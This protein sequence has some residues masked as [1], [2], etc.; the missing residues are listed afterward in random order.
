MKVAATVLGPTLAGGVIKRRP[1]MMG[2]LEKMQADTNAVRLM[3]DLRSRYRAPLVELAVPG[4]SFALVLSADEVGRVLAE[5]PEP[6]SPANLEKR[7]AL[8]KFQPHG[9]LIS[10]GG[11]RARRRAF[12][13]KALETPQPLHHLTPVVQAKIQEEVAALP[14]AG[15][16]DWEQFAAVWWRIVRRVVLGD[17]ARDDN[18]TTELLDRLRRSSNW[19]YLTPRHSGLQERVLARLRGHLTR[20]EAG[21]LAEVIAQ[22][23]QSDDDDPASQVGHWLFAFDAAAMV[24]FRALALLATHPQAREQALAETPPDLP[25]LRASVLDTVRLWPTTPAILRDIT[26]E[27]DDLPAGTGLL[28]YTPFFHRDDQNLPYAHSFVPEIWLD[29]RAQQNPALV[30]FSAGPGEC[31]ARNLVLMVTS[32]L[33]AALLEKRDFLLTSGQKLGPAHALPSTLDNFGLT[34]SVRPRR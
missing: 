15:T 20:A 2:L 25:H 19:A 5:S 24:S 29:G 26:K 1:K 28:V 22:T 30:P 34:F 11:E 13:E 23:P 9:V 7:A 16:L 3:Q 31:P 4:R 21:S 27:I 32:V 10:K 8:E 12:N 14:A 18:T 6:F 33:L 17:G